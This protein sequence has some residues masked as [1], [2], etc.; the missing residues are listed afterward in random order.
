MTGRV[1]QIRIASAA[2]GP[3]RALSQ[4]DV[5]A[6]AGLAGDRYARRAGYWLDDRVSRDLTLIEAEALDGLRQEHGIALAP[7]ET[8][9]NLTTRGVKLEELIN[10]Y[11]W[12]GEVLARG[13]RRCDP[14]QHLVELTGKPL[15]RPLVKKGGLR[16]DVL[17]SGR[18]HA[19]DAIQPVDEQRGVGVLVVRG[20]NVLVGRRRSLRGHGTWSFPG[21]KPLDHESAEACA[22][23]ELYEETGLAGSDPQGIGQSLAGVPDTRE[24]FRTDFIRVNNTGGEPELREPDKTEGWT[25]CDWERLPV[26]LFSPVA[27]FVA[28]GYQP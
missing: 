19:G 24:V 9:R 26:P 1:E 20:R 6:G 11:F 18:I 14:C 23:R 21:G 13:T 10:C 28:A 2:G 12:V 8:R 7:G 17:T 25:W 16:A 4:A 15:L 22:L 3:M 27:A 5:I